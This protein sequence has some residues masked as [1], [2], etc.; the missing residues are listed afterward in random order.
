MWGMKTVTIPVI[1]G[2]LGLIK[3]GLENTQK[4]PGAI[5]IKELQKK[6]NLIRNSSHTKEGSVLKCNIVSPAVPQD[7]GLDLALQEKNQELKN[8]T[9]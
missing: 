2:A 3:K 9:T 1:I 8:C 5:N 6:N 4:I 7:H